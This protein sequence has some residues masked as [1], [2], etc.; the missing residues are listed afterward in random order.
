[1]KKDYKG[2]IEKLDSKNLNIRDSFKQD[3]KSQLFKGVPMKKTNTLKFSELMKQRNFKYVGSFAVVAVMAL[4]L[5]GYSAAAQRNAN[6]QSIKEN[7]ELSENLAS[8]LPI[9]QIRER[10]LADVAAGITITSIELETEEG[11]TIYKV[12]FSDGTFRFY[13]AT[14]GQA[15]VKPS[16]IESDESVPADFVAGITIQQARDIASAERPG[17]TITKIELETEE[18]VVVYSVRFADGGRVDVSATDGSVVR[19]RQAKDSTEASSSDDDSDDNSGSNSGSGSDDSDEAED[20][21]NDDNS[22][23]GSDDSDEAEDESSD[24]NSGSNSGSGSGRN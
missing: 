15:Y 22:G 8:V 21:S 23:S 13:D 20:E 6:R 17:Q 4:S 14:T 12:K 19:V 24:D 10:A 9:E 5:F 3:L 16:E 18:G 1:M 2:V 7:L 11:V